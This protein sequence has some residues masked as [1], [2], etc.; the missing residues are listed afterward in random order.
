MSTPGRTKQDV[1]T[2]WQTITTERQHEPIREI[3]LNFAKESGSSLADVSDAS[4]DMDAE[5]RMTT[6]TILD[7]SRSLDKS[8]AD[9]FGLSKLMKR[10]KPD[11]PRIKTAIKS[12]DPAR[13][14][15]VPQ[16][17]ARAA[18]AIRHFSN[19]F[20]Q[21]HVTPKREKPIALF[22]MKEFC[23]SY[24]SLDSEPVQPRA[25]LRHGREHVAERSRVRQD[26]EWDYP[27]LP[28]G[29]F[30]ER[31]SGPSIRQVYGSGHDGHVL[32]E[33]F[34]S[35]VPPLPFPLISLPEAAMLQ[36][37]RRE[38][39]EEDHTDPAGS[40]AAKARSARSGTISTMSSLLGPATPLSAFG[41]LPM[42]ISAV[43][44]DTLDTPP[45]FSSVLRRS[46]LTGSRQ[47]S[48]DSRCENG[49]RGRASV[50]DTRALGLGGFSSSTR[51]RRAKHGQESL[52]LFTRSEADLIESAREDMLYR[53][54]LSADEDKQPRFLFLGIMTVTIFF[55]L[56]GLVALCGRFDST[57]S[58]YS[59]GE[60]NSLTR[61][62]RA[63]LKQQLLVEAVVYP[64]LITVLAVYYSVHGA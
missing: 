23:S 10:N 47:Q 42:G 43:S 27:N 34:L 48:G 26:C 54:G 58:W 1:D 46:E 20:R 45:H 9:G 33:R 4:E 63:I 22:E 36:Y 19:P 52:E 49:F 64:V 11:E 55:P 12:G 40:F 56:I 14:S 2:D 51:Q 25:P 30:D 6:N 61:E 57:I 59:H 50:F 3:E 5:E 32:Q 44:L 7:N 53:R 24:E 35:D 13:A 17:P 62:Q 15:K 8:K 29:T 39:G 38:R 18:D 31:Q 16:L 21:D 37:F 28:V 41:D 60:I